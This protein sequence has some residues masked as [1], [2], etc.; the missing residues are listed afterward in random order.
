MYHFL[1]L[2]LLSLLSHTWA[3]PMNNA[4]MN[5]SIQT[6]LKRTSSSNNIDMPT[7][8]RTVTVD[9]SL[10]LLNEMSHLEFVALYEKSMNER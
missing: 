2:S 10:N 6:V 5:K 7:F 4:S 1:L 3:R 8:K 9:K